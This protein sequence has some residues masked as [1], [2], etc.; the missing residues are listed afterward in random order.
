MTDQARPDS[1]LPAMLSLEP[2]I[3]LD[4]AAVATGAEL[5]AEAA[6]DQ[7]VAD[8]MLETMML[9]TMENLGQPVLEAPEDDTDRP[10]TEADLAAL[11]MSD[12]KD[13]EARLQPI[14]P[15]DVYVVDAGVQGYEAL[16]DAV[17][18]DAILVLVGEGESGVDA[19]RAAVEG[20]EGL[21][22]IHILS[23]GEAGEIELGTDVLTAATVAGEHADALRA[24][25][26][27]LSESG[28]ILIYGCD[29]GQ[30]RTAMSALA[31]VTGADI[32]ASTDDTGAAAVGGDWDLEAAVGLIEA[33]GFRAA[34]FAGLLAD[35]DGD[36][37]DDSVDRD[38]DNDGLTDAEEGRSPFRTLSSVNFLDIPDR[39]WTAGPQDGTSS[40]SGNGPAP[41][42]P[43]WT[44]GDI[45]GESVDGGRMHLFFSFRSDELLTRTE[46]GLTPGNTYTFAVQW[47]QASA[48]TAN[49]AIRAEGGDL[50]LS[51][52]GV[53]TRFQSTDTA[54]NDGWQTAT[55][56]FVADSSGQAE[57]AMGV[58][59]ESGDGFRQFPV[60][61]VD[62]VTMSSI[63]SRD[64]DGDG[65]PDYLDLDSDNDG[66]S[67]L[68]ESGSGGVD[69]DRDGRLDAMGA[70]AGDAN[71]DG[72]LDTL[73]GSSLVSP[74]Q[75]D[76]DG[77]PDYLDLD[78]DGDSIP[79]AVEARPTS[80]GNAI[81]S[82]TDTDVDGVLDHFDT[83][84]GHGGTFTAPKETTAGT[85]DYINFDS[86]G[87]GLSDWQES[88]LRGLPSGVGYG[89]AD[90]TLDP[91]ALLNR[92]NDPS[93]VD[94]RSA[95]DT[96]GDGVVDARDLDD[97]N[98]GIAD[99]VEHGPDFTFDFG[100][101]TD[102][103]GFSEMPP[104]VVNNVNRDT[105]W[106]TS[107]ARYLVTS[108]DDPRLQV[109]GVTF[110]D[111]QT[112]S[113]T[114]GDVFAINAGEASA[115]GEE[116][117]VLSFSQTVLPDTEYVLSFAHI[118]WGRADYTTDER[119]ELYVN[120]NGNRVKTL[121]GDAG[122]GR[123]AWTHSHVVIRSD[124]QG[125]LDVAISVKKGVDEYGNDY[126]LDA[127]RL[128]A[129]APDARAGRDTDGDGTP[130]QFDLDSD[131]DGISD[132]AEGGLGGLDANSD[133]VIDDV[134]GNDSGDGHRDG[135]GTMPRDTDGD[136]L[137]DHLDLDSDADFIPD[138][139]E[140]RP[141]AGYT[142]IASTVDADGDGVIDRFD[143]TKGF[144]GSFDTPVN[145]D[146]ADLP[147]YRDTDSDN[148]EG[149]DRAEGGLA[150]LGATYADPDGTLDPSAL[151]RHSA[152]APE[153]AFRRA[154]NAAPGINLDPDNSGGG[155]DD[156]GTNVTLVESGR[157][158]SGAAGS[159][160]VTLADVDAVLDDMGER[161]LVSLT[162]VA[163]GVKDG[164][165]ESL[166][167]N[168][169]GVTA[170][171]A[172]HADSKGSIFIGGVKADYT[173]AAATGTLTVASMD[174]TTPF[175]TAE[176]TTFLRAVR[177]AHSGDTP[178][179]S[180]RTFDFQ[181]TDRA[182][183]SSG[184]VRA[185]VAVRA[186]NDAPAV[187]LNSTVAQADASGAVM[188]G[189][190]SPVG[191]KD[192][193]VLDSSRIILAQVETLGRGLEGTYTTTAAELA[194]ADTKDFAGALR[195]EN[196]VQYIFATPPQLEA[197][198]SIV[199]FYNGDVGG[200]PGYDVT[201]VLTDNATQEQT[202]IVRDETI[203]ETGG[204]NYEGNTF[205]SDTYRL[206]PGTTYIM[207][208]YIHNVDAPRGSSVLFD[209]F[210]I[211]MAVVDVDHA[212]TFEE[213]G[214]AVALAGPA[215]DAFDPEDDITRLD[216]AVAGI[217]D[218]A[219]ERLTATDAGGNTVDIDLSTSG[220]TG[221]LTFGSTTFALGF[222]G[223]TLSVT[224][225]ARP[226][227][228]VDGGD[229]DA[230][231]R[232]LRYT[233]TS[234]NPT[235]ADRSFTFRVTD[236]AGVTSDPAVSTVSVT[237][238]N[239]APAAV[240]DSADVK[241]DGSVTI[242]VLRNDRDAE[243]DT[244]AID[245]VGKPG[246]GTAKIVD[247]KILY[248]PDADFSGKDSFTYTVID[249]KGGRSEATVDVTVAPLN[250]APE[251][252][253]DIP[254]Q[255]GA[256]GRA[257]VSLDASTSFRDVDGDALR[258]SASGLPDGL[259]IDP[260]TGTI[261]GTPAS[262]SSQ[263]G[264]NRDGVH[265]VTV[266]AT[267]P[268]GGSA[269]AVFTWTVGN[270]APVMVGPVAD[271]S[272]TDGGAVR[273]A[274]D[275]ADPDGD[276]LR[277]SATGLP[278]GL[279]IDPAT[280][281]VSG[282]LAGDA[283]RSGPYSITVSVS[284]GQGGAVSDVFTLAVTNPAPVV[285]SPVADGSAVDG[286]AVRLET[287]FADPDGDALSYSATGL[288]AGLS[289]DPV[290]GIISGT[291][292]SDA[293]RGGPYTVV[294]T[295]TDGDGASADDAFTLAVANAAPVVERGVGPRSAVDGGM[296][297]IAATM[298]DPDG[299]ALRYSATGLPAGLS[300]DPATGLISG[301]LAADA[302]RNGPYRITVS[303]NDGEG[304]EASDTFV[305]D[306]AN[307][308]PTLEA[309]TGDRT[310]VDG[311]TLRLASR[312]ADPDGD[313]LSYS[314]T[315]LPEGV[316]IDPATGV[317]S[318][319]LAPDAS[320]GGPYSVTVRASDGEGGV[321]ESAFTLD[322]LNAAPEPAD[323][324]ATVAEDT[325]TALDVLA[326]D[327]DPDGDAL[328][329]A[330]V[331]QGTHGSVSTV[332]GRALYTPARDFTGRD[333]FTYTVEDADGA[334]RSATVTVTVAPANDAP[335][336]L[337]A[338]ARQT[339]VDAAPLVPL[340]AGALFR[341]VDGDTLAFALEGAPEWLA[342]DPV[343]GI[344]TGTPPAD[345]SQS[346]T[347]GGAGGVYTFA[348]T[349][350]DPAG[351][352]ASERVAYAVSNTPVSA[353]D[354]AASGAE[355][356]GVLSGNVLGN[357]RD[358]DGDSLRVEALALADGTRLPVGEAVRLPE[359]TLRVDA[360]GGYSFAPAPDYNGTLAV[361]YVATDGEGSV[362]AASLTLTVEPRPDAPRALDAPA[363][364]AAAEGAALP[365]IEAAELFRDPDGQALVFSLEGAPDWVVVD[366]RTGAVS[367][368]A[369]AD[370][371]R[372]GPVAF[373]VVATDPDGEAAR[374]TLVLDLRNSAPDA[375]DD[376]AMGLE[377]TST[378]LDP[379]ANDRDADGDS[380]RIIAVD[381]RPVSPGVPVDV[382]G[383]TVVLLADGRVEFTPL[384][385]FHGEAGF[386]YT[387]DD[388]GGGTGEAEVRLSVAPANDA[389]A[390]VADPADRAS[391]DGE[392]IAPA[393]LSGV[394]GDVDGDAL[395]FS[396]TG[397]PPGLALDPATGVVS[398]TLAG[399]ASRGGPYTVTVT[400]TD[401]DG[402]SASA[403][404]AWEVANT[405][406]EAVS[407]DAPAMEAESGEPFTMD[408]GTLFR[409]PDGDAL[410]FSAADLPEGL[411][412]DPATG[413]ISGR[414]VVASDTPYVIVVT[415]TD[416]DGGSVSATVG[417]LAVRDGGFGD[418]AFGDPD[419]FKDQAVADEGTLRSGTAGPP[420]SGS[421]IDLQ[422]WFGETRHGADAPDVSA[423]VLRE[424][425]HRGGSLL[426]LVEGCGVLGVEAVVRPDGLALG[427]TLD[428]S[429]VDG[430]VGDG[431]CDVR[432]WTVD[433][434]PAPDG[435]VVLPRH[436][437]P[438]SLSLEVRAVLGDGR[439]LRLPVS[440]DTRSGHVERAGEPT[441]RR[442]TFSE[443]VGAR[444]AERSAPDP[445]LAAM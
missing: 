154:A 280:G 416:A 354:D 91:A 338:P 158:T 283:S 43:T 141:T 27:S 389:P 82:R 55:V 375:R 156:G 386:R 48:T 287:G 172:L 34:A 225:A 266:T 71:R 144:G 440:V 8:A 262:D 230:L 402:G 113:A 392:T 324:S 339:G 157:T 85:P 329:L 26:A 36:G 17:P 114:S 30:D 171:V 148:R 39:G 46:S 335:E 302:S 316:S 314:A 10:L 367:G 332:D 209:D 409:D 363:P 359:G 13:T 394:F 248:T 49:G 19:L 301:T 45:N 21:G 326:N 166:T 383:G 418:G 133:G 108:P 366:A 388:G 393:S 183:L 285:A 407:A 60:I 179:E 40:I 349:A 188:W 74:R 306:V 261:S 431:V 174:G 357:D 345:A 128:E 203:V 93:E 132:L 56:S 195:A 83:Q 192:A 24:I 162:V 190:N 165:E 11:G 284:D 384:P 323:D 75:T 213:N 224:D 235:D 274:T 249:G 146:G 185:T 136:R 22:S 288:P 81:T 100:T 253:A 118:V 286:D 206:N 62:T 110:T 204:G 168:Y 186:T 428:G 119:G 112:G 435:G 208:V 175:G 97:D 372:N 396:A 437:L 86:D 163:G 160:L 414:P 391:R 321:A 198:T 356:G 444:D 6:L 170:D 159:G 377:D 115:P 61:V 16:V 32:A 58:A 205:A 422:R 196:Y 216:V 231:L 275:F 426:R 123:D 352:G 292:A 441:V 14:K 406:P 103:A 223:T 50:L 412:I 164:A 15:V 387:A 191:T 421:P 405:P 96:D 312:F 413:V 120:V 297:R 420:A 328:R 72:L 180:A 264:L 351:A 63:T 88:G 397:L 232:A 355:D 150:A 23:H 217:A 344:V 340:D 238:V 70:T 325:A 403:V 134:R 52:D 293:S 173:Y 371:G 278:T 145:T 241:E 9:E 129:A 240:A 116:L 182:G 228:E 358:A 44:V 362:D 401:P 263:G 105:L 254:A 258:Y 256:D 296:V 382:R 226:G 299:D 271:T 395:V 300:V 161:D 221:E 210:Q 90:G 122:L 12:E 334:T 318:G 131:N 98:D 20:R 268:K 270:P 273:I 177:Y 361:G 117:E 37:V 66:I 269:S 315:G 68:E 155:A 184:T 104:T 439:T 294:V 107:D 267:D 95:P 317:I 99:D 167:L 220:G 350:T 76:G 67:D 94:Y 404:F 219:S 121:Q 423:T 41:R 84:T 140:A 181:V 18:E 233:H 277:Y 33:T 193:T 442:S 250:D 239:D 279:V 246:R 65:T 319:T 189:H 142:S 373:A 245:T 411:L 236:S 31:A 207:R 424:G 57:I 255:K 126:M 432:N 125:R 247:G 343:T 87:D 313:T 370:A 303:A 244:L 360:D 374:V 291:L 137:P 298:R 376:T 305:L 124:A 212:A 197:G 215:A 304:G 29:F 289:I 399:D 77:T 419:A 331:S 295:A 353:G 257:V 78:S 322:V 152:N 218:G 347:G 80:A 7:A 42:R 89:D 417:T 310:A 365:L 276:T 237:P 187:D 333:S 410:V 243:G 434:K 348:V 130:D 73:D 369:P 138:A 311:Q 379:L 28:D 25:G 51:V 227:A 111:F 176:L 194:G 69:A 35:T 53:V 3:L 147:D 342:I 200:S 385:D 47:Q 436:D 214:S 127:V 337:G 368:T 242:D 251:R 54:S 222:D 346:S 5:A 390:A 201:I 151:P 425:R 199:G 430:G 229:L 149:D 327:R 169:G 320:R 398:G 265:A 153:V 445:L 101:I 259:A 443:Q 59:G 135:L 139:V 378:I 427:F 281:V 309:P 282:T 433:G 143:T 109:P 178:T 381:G 38:S 64:T 400:A 290:T 380:L 211:R 307:P 202:V 364:V 260:K 336:S 429:A 252:I 308:A 330:S 1:T 4:A 79:D 92:D 415:A 102:R 408:A 234:D 106:F 272:A 2:R 341:D 438:D